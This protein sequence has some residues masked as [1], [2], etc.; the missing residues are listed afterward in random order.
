MYHMPPRALPASFYFLLLCGLIAANVSIYRIIFAPRALEVTVLEVGKGNAVLVRTSG[1]E[2]LLIDAGPDASILRALGSALPMWQRNIDAI[3]LT[4]TKASLVGGLPEVESRYHV[5]T[6]I[7]IG[8]TVAPYGAS[9]I[10][11]NSRITI[12]APATFAISYGAT[13]LTIS[14]TTP[15]GVYISNGKT[16]VY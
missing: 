3:I 14:S 2:T 4:S 12:I 5:S 6:P 1:G 11:D 8:D 16:I 15:K 10:F 7:Y 13:T 9:F